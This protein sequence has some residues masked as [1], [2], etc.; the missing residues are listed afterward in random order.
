MPLASQ[1][2]RK[3]FISLFTKKN[4]T[5]PDGRK[6]LPFPR[7]FSRSSYQQFKRKIF[8]YGLKKNIYEIT[9][10][11]LMGGLKFLCSTFP[12]SSHQTSSFYNLLSE[13]VIIY[14]TI[15]PGGSDNSGNLSDPPG[16]VTQLL[17]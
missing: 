2:S 5:L 8:Y 4:N 6:S 14:R 7:A 16:F 11:K 9:H 12:L 10:S 3:L 13:L 1:G 17:P 15:H